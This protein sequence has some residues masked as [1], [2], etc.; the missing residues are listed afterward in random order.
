LVYRLR[1]LGLDQELADDELGRAL[2]SLAQRRGF[3]SN[4]K[5]LA[6]EGEDEGQVKD[7]I[8]RLREDMA[9]SEARTLGEHYS[10]LDPT[11]NRIRGL[12]QWTGRDM[13][14]E[15]FDRLCAAQQTYHPDALSDA[16]VAMLREA[17]F[18]QRPLKPVMPGKCDLETGEY[19]A[20]I[21]HPMNQRIRLVQVVNNLEIVP[22]S[23]LGV[24]E[25]LTDEQRGLLIDT[26]EN[27]GD[28]TMA[29]ARKLI[30]VKGR[31]WK[32]NLEEGGEKR[33][34]GNRTSSR[35]A[36]AIGEAWTALSLEDQEKLV[37]DLLSDRES[38]EL[39]GYLSERFTTAQAHALVGVRI[40]QGYASLS[41]KAIRRL[42]PFI[43][44]GDRYGAARHEV[45]GD[46]LRTGPALDKLPPA[47]DVFGELRNPAVERS[48]SELRK[49][50]NAV[51]AK[52][53][54]PDRIHLEVARDLKNPKKRREEIWKRQRANEKSRERAA[55]GILSEFPSFQTRHDDIQKYL[56]WEECNGI[57]PYTGRSITLSALFGADAQFEIEHIIPRSRSLDNSFNNKTLCAATANRD[58]GNRTP[59]EY[60]SHDREAWEAILQRVRRFKGAS[61]YQK[62]RRFEME[63][64]TTEGFLERQLNDTRYASKLSAEF[65][66]LLYGGINA[67]G[68]QRV[69][70]SPGLATWQLRNEWG[71]NSILNDGPTSDGGQVLKTRDDHRHHA[72]DALVIALTT[73]STVKSLADAA[74]Y[75][76][77]DARQMP[78]PAPWPDF[79]DSVREG[80]DGIVV[81][82]RVD[83]R[84]RRQ[85]HNDTIY[86][87]PYQRLVKGKPVEVRRYRKWLQNLSTKEVGNI[88]DSAVRNAVQAKLAEIRDPKKF[89]EE[90]N[91][92]YLPAKKGDP[93]IIRSARIERVQTVQAIGKGA[94]ERF[95]KLG[96]NHHLEVFAVLD[97]DGN[98]TKWEGRLVSTYEAMQRLRAKNDGKESVIVQR[99]HGEGTRFKFSLSSG[100]VIELDDGDGRRVC[101]V[102]TVSQ[103]GELNGR[104]RAPVVAFVAMTDSRL[105]K[106]IKAAKAWGVNPINTFR[107]YG[108][109]KVVI[110]PIGEVAEAHD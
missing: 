5:T 78:C 51:V 12:G 44:A 100:D 79:V 15:E 68:R 54:K 66:G 101:V 64:V 67:G 49:V 32:F 107:K 11:K 104:R 24:P 21:A 17:L 16:F 71:L 35:I 38:E 88:V 95:V 65:V 70:V 57:C 81:S 8:A 84:V 96:S 86:S 60:F 72:V 31:G 45:Y 3:K 74:A 46:T 82:H 7:G 94:R 69:Q 58:K 6:K 34:I 26:L 63:E 36:E 13:F 73:N 87:K 109:R 85:M 55:A 110:S 23:G 9:E 47:R 33:L 48:L 59:F 37:E 42:M 39:E 29:A 75:G 30:G 14:E 97:K 77:R 80:V 40:E 52:Y 4:R 105:K 56:L 62:L 98:E 27:D 18:Y 89:A 43:E 93:T 41:L 10:K 28:L 20:P 102:R 108:C 50:V 103:E 22:P 83:R 106:D 90:S 19:R 25:R 1:A 61:A 91:L 92:P 76:D 99:D 2:Y 53:E